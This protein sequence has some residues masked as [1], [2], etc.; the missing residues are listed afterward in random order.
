MSG[1]LE[2]CASMGPGK[3]SVHVCG[4]ECAVVTHRACLESFRLIDFWSSGTAPYHSELSKKV[5][6]TS[7][8]FTSHWDIDIGLCQV[9]VSCANGD[10]R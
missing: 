1:Q 8:E 2:R 10:T 5:R 9:I 7:L 6:M 4:E 3:G